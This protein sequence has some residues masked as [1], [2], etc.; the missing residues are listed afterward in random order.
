MSYSHL[1]GSL[2]LVAFLLARHALGVEVL[3][4]VVGLLGHVG[5][6]FCLLY[7]LIS[8][9]NS[10]A[11][12]AFVREVARGLCGSL[13]RLGYLLLGVDFGNFKN[14][15]GIAFVHNVAFFDADLHDTGQE[16]TTDTVLADL[17]LALDDLIGLTQCEET[18]DG[19]DKDCDGES[20]YR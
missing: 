11:A 7:K 8:A 17:Y 19:N 18:D 20:Q 3:H 15:K 5:C 10:F 16:L 9:L 12:R 14:G 1:P 2:S 6:G 13:R 4:A